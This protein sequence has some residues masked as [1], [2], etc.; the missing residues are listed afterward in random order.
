ME[1]PLGD[2]ETLLFGSL[3]ARKHG[4]AE[5]DAWFA[6][7]KPLIVDSLA[8]S[9][10]VEGSWITPSVWSDLGGR[11]ASTALM[12][13]AFEVYYSYPFARWLD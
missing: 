9:G 12:T 4:G 2:A 8:A 13:L 6:K 1:T 11:V 7:T 10:C 5:R 3:A